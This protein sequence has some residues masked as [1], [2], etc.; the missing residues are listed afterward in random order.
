MLGSNLDLDNYVEMRSVSRCGRKFSPDKLL[1]RCEIIKMRPKL[2]QQRQEQQ[3]ILKKYL[4]RKEQ[5]EL[6]ERVR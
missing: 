2:L 3:L 4:E 6:E 5:E 1:P